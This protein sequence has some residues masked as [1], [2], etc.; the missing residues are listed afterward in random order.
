MAS[1]NAFFRMFKTQKQYSLDASGN[2]D[3]SSSVSGQKNTKNGRKCSQSHKAAVSQV[4]CCTAKTSGKTLF[5]RPVNVVVAKAE[6]QSAVETMVKQYDELPSW[7]QH[8]GKARLFRMNQNDKAKH[9]LAMDLLPA[10][11]RKN[12]KKVQA[13]CDQLSRDVRAHTVERDAKQ[14]ATQDDDNKPQS[15]LKTEGAQTSTV[16]KSVRFNV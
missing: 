6:Y 3:S 11:D 9:Q 8:D 7:N 4:V 5:S 13:V 15:I 16:K 1:I 12:K 2:N 14:I 10:G